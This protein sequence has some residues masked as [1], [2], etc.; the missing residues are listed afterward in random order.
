MSTPFLVEPAQ[1]AERGPAFRLVFRHL[2]DKER[3]ARVANAQVLLHRGE[4]AAEGVLVARGPAGVS[5]ALVCTPAPGAGGLIWPPQTEPPDDAVADELVRRACTWL[6]QSGVKLA[7]A[8]L[9]PEDLP[10]GAPLLRNGFQ[11]ITTLW[12]LRHTL[13]LSA[14]LLAVGERLSYRPYPRDPALFQETLLRTYEGTA[15]CPEVSGVR[16]IDEVI[17][18]HVAQ[19]EHDPERW[20]LALRRDQPVGVLLL[21]RI[22]EWDGWDVSYVGIV[23]EARRQGCGSELMRKAL[24]EARAAGASQL[25]LSV[26]VRNRP[27]WE[28]YRRLGFEPFEQREVLLAVWGR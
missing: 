14:V 13:E 17:A 8:L 18:G 22:P 28:L 3:E 27:A 12:Y 21:T 26:D 19:G 10:L 16:T 25:T 20:W 11:H 23:P 2:P 5:G 24:L 7:Q 4:L 6:R 1:P 9:P 15:D